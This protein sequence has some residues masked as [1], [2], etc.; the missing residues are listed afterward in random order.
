[1]NLTS[2]DIGMRPVGNSTGHLGTMHRHLGEGDGACCSTFLV[3][4]GGATLALPPPAACFGT[5]LSS[6]SASSAASS[7]PLRIRAAIDGRGRFPR[8]SSKL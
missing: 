1:M 2:A 6:L 3:F 7:S 8:F 5:S 4:L